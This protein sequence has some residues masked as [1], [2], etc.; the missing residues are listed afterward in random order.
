MIVLKQKS[1]SIGA[2]ASALCL[3]HCVATPVI[4]IAQS[5]AVACSH[6]N[7]PTWWGLIDYF[8]LIISFFAVYRSTQT[9]SKN[10]MKT[11]LWLSLL[12]LFMVILNEK[13]AWFH[14]VEQIIYLPAIALITL[15]LY[16]RKYCQCQSDKCCVN[17]G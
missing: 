14:L 16:N 13:M 15:H 17:E 1:D 12:A 2:I 7:T 8:F 4:F 6:E 10:W 11:A 5:C 3:I 9:T